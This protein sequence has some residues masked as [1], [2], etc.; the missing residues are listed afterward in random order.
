MK[1][2]NAPTPPF[3]SRMLLI[4]VMQ[5]AVVLACV[6][7]TT[8]VAMS[9]QE[10][11]IRSATAD[12]VLDVSR[13]LADLSQVRAA[14]Q[15]SPERGQAELQP[16]ADILEEASGVD[17]VVIT[18]ADGV[19]L[20]HP[21]ASERGLPVSTDPSAVLDGQVFVGTETGTIG[22]TLR[23]KVPVYD[24]ERIVGSASVGILES[25]ISED[26]TT[27]VTNLVPWVLVSVVVGCLVS[28]LLT[29]VVRRSVRRLAERARDAE[30]QRRVAS[31]LRDQTH[32][33]RTRLHVI[34]GL[35]A[36][37]ENAAALDYVD[38]LAPP[39]DIADEAGAVDDP[40]V[41]ALLLSSAA[42]YAAEG[43][44]LEIDPLSTVPPGELGDGDVVVLANLCRN[45]MEASPDGRVRVLVVAD[46]TDVHIDV[47]DDGPGVP[48]EMIDRV[49]DRGVSTKGDAADRGVGLDLVR[50]EVVRRGGTVT[51]GRS[52]AGGARFTVDMPSIHRQRA[53]S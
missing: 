31:A 20:T 36:E 14:V 28:A 7:V 35:V 40:A 37:G 34:R 12:R 24:G 22:P 3:R 33:F 50:R 2:S 4:L 52:E 16:L 10:R 21:T 46:G 29:G 53:R 9:V 47:A 5:C 44:T 41:R 49:F 48:P 18:D 32:E 43:G 8:V 39:I 26:L 42:E 51:I 11:S 19:R 13:S 6:A 30:A 27:A 45:A 23:A 38:A 15:S 25:R 17:Y 1:T